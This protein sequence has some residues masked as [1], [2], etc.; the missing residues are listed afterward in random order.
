MD[1]NKKI[2]DL[3]NERNWSTYDLARE[4]ILT[5]STISSAM[6]RGTPPKIETLQAICEAFGITLSQFFLEDE[7]SEVLSK[8]EKELVESFRRL[9]P[10]KQQALLKFIDR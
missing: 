4:A 2:M 10:E 8:D 1:I 9:P 5:H 7:Q 3:C 6:Q